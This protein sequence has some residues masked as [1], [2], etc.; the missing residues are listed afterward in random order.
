MTEAS[1]RRPLLRGYFHLAAAAAAVVGLVLL[2]LLAES[3][4]AYIGGAVFAVSLVALYTT[5][6]TYHVVTWGNRMR[7]VM[8]RLDHSMIFVLIAGTYTPF[9]LLVASGAWGITIL[10][11][12]WSIAVAG[13][14]LKMAWPNAPR[15]LGVG[16][17]IATGWVALVA[18]SEI[19]NWFAL[20]PLLLLAGGGILYTA[21]GVIYALKRPDPFPRVFGYHEVFHLFVI[22]GSLLHF[23][24]IAGYLMGA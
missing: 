13:I 5:S 11:V 19:A 9:C 23:T 18:A 6:A 17:Y 4:E 3:P 2:V 10:A 22:A 15:W 14:L 12:V 21:G 1:D 8:K 20:V 7:G 24:L 16:L